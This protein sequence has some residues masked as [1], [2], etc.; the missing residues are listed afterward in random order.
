VGDAAEIIPTKYRTKTI[1]ADFVGKAER[2][3]PGSFGLA[4]KGTY[5]PYYKGIDKKHCGYGRRNATPSSVRG[6]T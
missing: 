1:D 3:P 2:S 5:K 6:S 4:A